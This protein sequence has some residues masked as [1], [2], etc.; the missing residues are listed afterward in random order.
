VLHRE[1]QFIL[2]SSQ[3]TTSLQE[4]LLMLHGFSHKEVDHYWYLN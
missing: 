2:L 1:K 4:E 3:L